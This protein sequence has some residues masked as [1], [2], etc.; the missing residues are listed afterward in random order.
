[1]RSRAQPG[2]ATTATRTSWRRW[3]AARR[4]S[5]CP[6]GGGAARQPARAAPEHRSGPQRV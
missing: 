6:S 1:V 4:D 2:Q 3:S 5:R